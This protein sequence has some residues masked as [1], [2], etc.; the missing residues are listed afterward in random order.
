M[1][2]AAA[3]ALGSIQHAA[4]QATPP[5]TRIP[6]PSPT[7][8]RDW[9]LPTG[10][11]YTQA[12]GGAGGYTIADENGITFWSA[13]RGLGGVEALGYPASRRFLL[14]GF[15]Y[16]VTQAALLQWRADRGAAVLGNTFELLQ[17]A[18]RDEWLERAKGIPRPVVDDGSTSYD[19]AVRI[20]L[21]WL[22][23]P[24]IRARFL[25]NVTPGGRSAWSERD[26]IELYGLPMSRPERF[27]PFV[28]QRF[29]R[30]AFQLWVD[31]VPGMPAPGSVT[32]VLG[33]DLLKEA[34][35]V[36]GAAATP[37]SPAALV[38]RPVALGATPAPTPPSVAASPTPSPSAQQRATQTAIAA[39]TTPPTATTRPPARTSPVATARA[40][41]LQSL[42]GTLSE[43]S[44]SLPQIS[45]KLG[46]V[47]FVVSN[48]GVLRHNLRVLGGGVDRKTPDL[49]PGQ[50]GQ[51]DVTFVDPGEYTVYCDIGDHE[52]LGMTLSFSVTP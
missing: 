38:D 23:E 26:A 32:A 27:G 19:D 20:R 8:E 11:F 36:S 29:Q 31:P 13:Y 24:A 1:L 39:A 12:G 42:D 3:L 17:A 49:R 28:T 45:A 9:D 7:P 30:V 47:R 18:G 34:G 4:A 44:I 15:V 2:L 5:G 48:T 6:A 14:D 43:Y 10:H 35:L 46:T 50:S 51:V 33:G 21:A 41:T 52:A 25:T 16:Q 37:H 40:G 22:T